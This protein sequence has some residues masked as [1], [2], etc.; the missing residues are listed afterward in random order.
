[1]IKKI[2]SLILI[3]V[4]GLLPILVFASKDSLDYYKY[5]KTKVTSQ[6]NKIDF[7]K[8][9]ER[10]YS[11]NPD[12]IIPNIRV[13][14]LSGISEKNNHQNVEK[15]S[16]PVADFISNQTVVVGSA[17]VQFTD[18]SANRPTQW[19]WSFPG[20]IPSTSNEQNPQVVYLTAGT[21]NVSLTV[22]NAF[23]NNSH[24]K[25]GY[26]QVNVLNPGAYNDNVTIG[27]GTNTQVW[28]LGWTQ[29][30]RFI[31]SAAIYTSAEIGQA[32]VIERIAW[33]TN[34]AQGSRYGK[35]YLKHVSNATFS[36]TSTWENITEGA[37]AV[38][39]GDFTNPA[40]WRQ[41]DLSTKFPYN[42]S[43]NLLVLVEVD[44]PWTNN[45]SAARY[46]AKTNS[47][48]VW[49]SGGETGSPPTGNGTL[50]ANRPNINF[51]FNIKKAAPV[52]DF[53]T[54]A[55]FE[56]FESHEDF[57]LSFYPWAMIDGDAS[58]TY[59]I[60][61]TYFPNNG[62]TG[63][64]ILFNPSNASP[65]LGGAWAPKSGNK[66][67]AC[68]AAIN[69]PN[70]DWLI[71][72]QVQLGSNSSLT[73]W[74]KS[75]TDTYGLERFRVGVSTTGTNPGDFT[76]IST[77]PYVEA[78]IAWTKYDYNLSAYNG[79]AVYIAIQCVS[80]DAFAF[81]VDDFIIHSSGA[82]V[83]LFEGDFGSFVDM[84]TGNPDVWAWNMPGGSPGYALEQHPKMQYNV[85]GTYNVSL[86]SAN[87]G[88]NNT[89]TK[90]AFVNV[91][92]RAPIADFYAADYNGFTND[93]FEPFIPKGG[94]VNF[95]D[96]SE[97]VPTAWSW[98][99][100]GGVPATASVKNPNGI[101]YSNQGRYDVVLNI[102]NNFGS[103]VVMAERYIN[104]GCCDYI[105]NILPLDALTYYGL[106]VQGYLPGH[107]EYEMTAY[108][109]K[110]T[111]TSAGTINSVDLLVVFAEGP[112][113][114][115]ISVWNE[116]GDLPGS[117]LGSKTIPMSGFTPM[118]WNVIDFDTPINVSGNFYIGYQ[119]NYGTPHDYNNHMFLVAMMQDRGPD[120]PESM[121]TVYGGNWYNVDWL[122]D[123][124][125]S[126]LAI[127]PHFCYEG[128][129]VL[130]Y[131]INASAGT[132]GSINPNGNVSVLE[133]GSQSFSINPN[134]G[135]HIDD[136]KVNNLS[137]GPVTN[138]EFSQV[139]ANHT[140]NAT[141]AINVYEIRSLPGP[142]GTINPSGN[143]NVTHGNNQTFTIIPDEGYRILDVVVNGSSVGTPSSY[144]FTNVQQ[145]HTLE[146]FFAIITYTIN[147]TS[148]PNGGI[149]PD[150]IVEVNHGSS[151]TFFMQPNSGYFV[152]NVF[153]NGA[154]M[155]AVSS[156]KFENVSSNHTLH[157]IFTNV[158]TPGDVN[159]D[160]YI[161][162]LD[163]VLMVQQIN[164][165]SPPG[166][167]ANNAD[168]NSDS[169]IN[170]ADL[171]LLISLVFNQ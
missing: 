46:T 16:P 66:Y 167:L 25:T 57:A 143:I 20:G 101:T 117:V 19:T 79:Q 24:T 58:A 59:S 104:V 168:L 4:I 1:M 102:S 22:T 96:A 33:Y 148:G 90:N 142:N 114:V 51:G 29:T 82:T 157:A 119:I 71:S 150:G 69:F 87:I 65:P 88:G 123:G 47:F 60:S 141:F 105:T 140:I 162:V 45:N 152:G 42:G 170:I 99:F 14:D 92:G 85:A 48:Q 113:S 138:Y 116:V 115:T 108:A 158:N 106:A 34:T 122:F 63:S 86:T 26:I 129:E 72:P 130:T 13:L 147:V 35:I 149:M 28:P 67:A 136:V 32:G 137:V 5:E 75:I 134:F 163:V 74:A 2:Y 37:I 70:N 159:G 56:G 118:A 36:S 112:S 77:N 18:L 155:G 154:S 110:F 124:L 76:I 55:Y 15:T 83:N 145:H 53:L 41:F 9:I 97:R 100:N 121:Y 161:N 164:G 95:K 78:P 52:A 3:I 171:T 91:T 43:S 12:F 62:Y 73:F 84:S 44:G 40:G 61:N 133:G 31:R 146:V 23:G 156:Y 109:E 125:A 8:G 17:K 153:V 131:N 135:Y 111:S 166:F 30:Q 144:T 39:E 127:I 7:S 160:G 50:S 64:F 93:Y 68:F 21:Y 89:H 10:D 165:N 11:K 54:P 120:A 49:A 6:S 107:N 169:V 81:F 132:N 151:P 38:W 139:W 103:D 80:N 128:A 126:A 27:T 94:Y 98:N